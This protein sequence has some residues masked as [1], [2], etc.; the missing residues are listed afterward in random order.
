MASGN[1]YIH[2]FNGEDGVKRVSEENYKRQFA[3]NRE[4]DVKETKATTSKKTS[5]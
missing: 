4:C 3:V 2:M 1:Q 5:E